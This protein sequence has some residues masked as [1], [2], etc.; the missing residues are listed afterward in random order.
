MIL[1]FFFFLEIYQVFSIIAGISVG[2]S[3]VI[4]EGRVTMDS[5]KGIRK[6]ENKERAITAECLEG[7]RR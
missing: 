3:D 1:D 5:R 4:T 2:L 6:V 7:G